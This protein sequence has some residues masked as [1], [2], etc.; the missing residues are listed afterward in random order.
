VATGD[1]TAAILDSE[2]DRLE[3][4]LVWALRS[5]GQL[6]TLARCAAALQLKVVER[7]ARELAGPGVVT[8]ID[9][10]RAL[11]DLLRE[12]IARLRPANAAPEPTP[13]WRLHAIAEGFYVQGKP[14]KEV[15]A[16]LGISPRTFHRER[17]AAAEALVTV[18]WQIE[19]HLGTI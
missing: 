18:V 13:A 16:E 10:G 4:V 2:R 15:A 12:A 7:R 8:D 19:T 1:A 5:R 3:Q 17:R 11:W 6:L 9:R 14:A